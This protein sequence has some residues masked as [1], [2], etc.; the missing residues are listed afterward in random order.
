MR[1]LFSADPVDNVCQQQRIPRRM[2]LY[3]GLKARRGIEK[4][5]EK[6]TESFNRDTQSYKWPQELTAES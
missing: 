2:T 4:V 5:K 6:G 3:S 1:A